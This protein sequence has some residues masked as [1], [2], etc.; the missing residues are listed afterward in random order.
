MH[1]IGIDDTRR[2]S[3]S[4]NALWEGAR[5]LPLV[6][7]ANALLRL[8]CRGNTWTQQR[9][10]RKAFLVRIANDSFLKNEVEKLTCKLSMERRSLVVKS[11]NEV[12]LRLA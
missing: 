5:P 7:E 4:S 3:P 9:Q 1:D 11:E 2:A 12:L 6:D 8:I 10:I